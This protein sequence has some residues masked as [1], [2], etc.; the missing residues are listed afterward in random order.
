M[1]I[2]EIISGLRSLSPK[3]KLM[4]LCGKFVFLSRSEFRAIIFEASRKDINTHDLVLALN[5]ES[6]PTPNNKSWFYIVHLNT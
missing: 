1:D 5:I 3:K 2:I 6:K 4:L